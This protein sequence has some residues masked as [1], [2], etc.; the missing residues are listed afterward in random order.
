[1]AERSYERL[2]RI[3]DHEFRER[4]PI[5]LY[6]S[7]NEFAQN[8]IIGDAGEGTLGVTDAL[9]QRNMFFFAGD[10]GQSEHT[11][12][13]EMVHV[14][15]FDIFAR[16][17]AGGGLQQLA[18]AQPPLWFMEGMAEYLTNGP[19]HKAT[20]A[21]MRDAALNGNIPSVE[22]MTMRPDQF[23]PYRFGQ[24]FFEYVADRWGDEVVGEI[25]NASV[26]LGIPRAF[27]RYTGTDLEDLG[28]EWKE[29]VQTT[30][31]PQVAELERPRRVAQPMLNQ[32]R[33]GGL[34]NVYVAPALSPDGRQIAFISLGSLLRAEVFL[35]LYLADANTG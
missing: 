21:V 16:G 14:F 3:L 25:M 7:R 19:G 26:S 20:A 33:T 17:R 18:Q 23:F 28:E 35:D 34:V 24:S 12:T 13:H 2:R 10:M 15:Q 9:R 30:Y 31:L 11:L 29:H 8:N 22:Q 5:I 6:G 32:R 1:M 27:R 4:K